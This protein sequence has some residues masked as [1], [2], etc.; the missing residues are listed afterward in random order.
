MIKSW[1]IANKLQ[2]IFMSGRDECCKR[3]YHQMDSNIF[4]QKTMKQNIT[5]FMRKHKDKRNDKIIKEELFGN[6]Y[7]NTWNIISAI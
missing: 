2:I 1:S 5:I 7:L 3:R 4:L 6:L